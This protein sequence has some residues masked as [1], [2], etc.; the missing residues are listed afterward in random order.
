MEDAPDGKA[1]RLHRDINRVRFTD[2]LLRKPN[3]IGYRLLNKPK[4]LF[5]PFAF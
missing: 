5:Q 4:C 1:S 2:P 3:E